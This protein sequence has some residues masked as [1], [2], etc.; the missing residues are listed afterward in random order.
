MVTVNVG[1]KVRFSVR[2]RVT[3]VKQVTLPSK[4]LVAEQ[5]C[6]TIILYKM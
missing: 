1:V 3:V 5:K 6:P 2:F 4:L